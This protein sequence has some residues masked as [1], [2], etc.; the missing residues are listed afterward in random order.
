MLNYLWAAVAIIRH[1]LKFKSV[2]SHLK[3]QLN[4]ARSN[5]L[6]H[7]IPIL[8]ERM[9]NAESKTEQSIASVHQTI[10]AIPTVPVDQSVSSILTVQET[11]AVLETAV[12]ILVPVLAEL[13]QIAVL[14]IIS[15]FAPAKNHIPAILTDLVDLFPLL[16]C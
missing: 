16:V 3:Y 10:S 14:Q 7:A 12:L 8:A 5:L 11:R 6:V 13:T 4:R 15:L 1:S 9:L 2:L